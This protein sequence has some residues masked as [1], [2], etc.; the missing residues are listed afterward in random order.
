MQKI[1]EAKMN[2]WGPLHSPVRGIT[3]TLNTHTPIKYFIFPGLK[4]NANVIVN[5]RS[6]Y[7]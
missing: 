1:Q 3:Y 5:Q 6:K 2:R 4:R 7:N